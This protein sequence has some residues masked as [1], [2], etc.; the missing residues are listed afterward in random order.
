[1][2]IVK[3][4][5]FR[6]GIEKPLS[7][8]YKHKQM[9]DG[10]LN[11][12]KT[13]TK[14]DSQKRHEKITSTPEGLEKERARHREKYHRLNYKEQQKIWDKDKPWKKSQ[15]YKNLSRKFKTPK[16]CELHHWN[17]NDDYLEDVVLMTRSEHKKLHQLIELDIEKRIFK[18][19][20]TGDYLYSK[21][22][23]CGFI[24]QYGF[25]YEIPIKN[26]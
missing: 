7:E 23:H 3:K 8:Y 6:C 1:M 22:Q 11:K 10:H 12:C 14:S 26:G 18:D 19:K 9:A 16:D 17:Y 13:C 25:N 2:D 15:V 24:L 4:V 5:C 21:V 20:L